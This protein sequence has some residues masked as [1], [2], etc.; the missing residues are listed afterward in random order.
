MT[1][2]LFIDNEQPIC[3][4]LEMFL[5]EKEYGVAI[6]DCG[7]TGLKFI[8]KNQPDI[9]ILDLLFLELMGLR[10]FAP[11]KNFSRAVE[12]FDYCLPR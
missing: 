10:C 7:E 2:I 6:S 5:R 11:S 9:V 4:T 1:K 12:Y 8:Q 3:A